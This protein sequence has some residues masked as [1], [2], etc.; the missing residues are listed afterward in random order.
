MK[1]RQVRGKLEIILQ[2]L[3]YCKIPR[4]KYHIIQHIN[5]TSERLNK[6]LIEMNPLI[7]PISTRGFVKGVLWQTQQRGIMFIKTYGVLEQ[8]LSEERKVTMLFG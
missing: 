4:R 5:L 2:I 3:E 7:K 8:L 1:R 6:L